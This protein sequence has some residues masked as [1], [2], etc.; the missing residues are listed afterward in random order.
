MN[1]NI[2]GRPHE[3]FLTPEQQRLMDGI[4]PCEHGHLYRLPEIMEHGVH[5][6]DF[7]SD[8]G[9]VRALFVEG[10]SVQSGVVS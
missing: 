5:V 7:D 3:Y 10:F 8:H 9:V 1:L 4:V 2:N 6:K